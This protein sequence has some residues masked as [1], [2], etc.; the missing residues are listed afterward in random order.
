M[1]KEKQQCL[2]C[3]KVFPLNS[4]YFY[5]DASNKSGFRRECKSCRKAYFVELK[6]SKGINKEI[7]IER[8]VSKMNAQMY[9]EKWNKLRMNLKDNRFTKSELL[10]FARENNVQYSSHYSSAICQSIYVKMNGIVFRS[11]IGAMSYSFSGDPI[12]FTFFIENPPMYLD[13]PKTQEIKTQEQKTIY[14][15]FDEPIIYEEK[16]IKNFSD[17]EIVNELRARGFEVIAK[18]TIEL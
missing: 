7:R 2:K 16:I 1:E 15:K 6:K 4:N 10:L 5:K 18:K 3:G 9:A 8:K 14:N 12:P 13:C 11:R 17:K